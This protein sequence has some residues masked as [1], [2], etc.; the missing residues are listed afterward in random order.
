M[1]EKGYLTACLII[2]EKLGKGML[3]KNS[4]LLTRE[5][6]WIGKA[7]HELKFHLKPRL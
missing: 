6:F 7:L 3:M 5:I 2:G 1:R 4:K